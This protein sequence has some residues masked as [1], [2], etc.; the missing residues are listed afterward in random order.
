MT[1][2]E[3]TTN[4]DSAFFSRLVPPARLCSRPLRG[5]SGTLAQA[6]APWPDVGSASSLGAPDQHPRAG[7]GEL[8]CERAPVPVRQLMDRAAVGAHHEDVPAAGDIAAAEEGDAGVV[9]QPDRVPS[10]QTGFVTV[11][12]L[13]PF[14][15]M[16]SIEPLLPWRATKAMREPSCDHTGAS[17]ESLV[18]A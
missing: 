10:D 12:V 3:C 17:S 8:R 16:T 15:F 1:A 11:W 18:S 7:P 9:R 6:S 4:D 5:H 14:A 2:H 13:L